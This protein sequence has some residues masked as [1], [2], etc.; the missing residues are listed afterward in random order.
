MKDVTKAHEGIS[1]ESKFLMRLRVY[2][3][4]LRG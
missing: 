3:V 1:P 4:R 2:F